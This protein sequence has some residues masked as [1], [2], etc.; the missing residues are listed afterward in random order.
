LKD[1]VTRPEGEVQSV[2]SQ[3][4]VDTSQSTMNCKAGV[5]YWPSWL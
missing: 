2:A 4:N 5:F 3:V 1:K